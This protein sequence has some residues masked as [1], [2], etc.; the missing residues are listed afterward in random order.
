MA[1][2]IVGCADQLFAVIARKLNENLIRV[3]YDSSFI[4]RGE[5]HLVRTHLMFGS[6]DFHAFAFRLPGAHSSLL[7]LDIRPRLRAF[8]RKHQPNLKEF[9][10]VVEDVTMGN[11]THVSMTTVD[12]RGLNEMEWA[13]IRKVARR[14]WSSRLNLITSGNEDVGRTVRGSL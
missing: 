6:R 14:R 3:V 8:C 7:F 9:N 4:G 2:D 13:E 10:E 11:I 1:D 5:E 12:G